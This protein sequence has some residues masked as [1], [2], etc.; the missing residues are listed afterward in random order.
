[1]MTF[2]I[3]IVLHISLFYTSLQQ[4]N[5]NNTFYKHTNII[6]IMQKVPSY[7]TFRQPEK[8]VARPSRN[9]SFI[10]GVPR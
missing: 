7:L 4:R 1:M 3:G 8:R 10:S 6:C 2:L 9:L 5:T